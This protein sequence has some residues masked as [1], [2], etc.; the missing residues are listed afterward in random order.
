MPT[1][2]KPALSFTKV[3]TIWQ[4]LEMDVLTVLHIKILITQHVEP[5]YLGHDDDDVDIKEN[6]GKTGRIV[7]GKEDWK[8]RRSVKKFGS[9]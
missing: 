9:G 5:A 2:F 3:N 8:L 1:H 4:D 7:V 6:V